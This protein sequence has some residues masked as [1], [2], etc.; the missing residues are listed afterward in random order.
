MTLP[1]FEIFPDARSRVPHI[2]LCKLPTGVQGLADLARDLEIGSLHVKRD[3]C[4]AAGYAGNK[5]RKLEFL[6][7][8]CIDRGAAEV[9]SFG[10]AGSNFA[11]ACAFHARRLG[12]GSI[13]ML[14]PQENA[15]YLRTNLLLSIASGADCHQHDHIPALLGSAVFQSL[16]RRVSGCRVCWIPAGGSSPAGVLG[17]VNAGLELRDQVRAGL[18]P[19]PDRIYLAMGSM[20][21]AAGLALGLQVAGLPTRVIGVRVV[22]ERYANPRKLE[23]LIRQTCSYARRHGMDLGDPGTA[24]DRISI[25]E[26]YLGAGYACPTKAGRAAAERLYGN[27][28]LQLDSTYSAKAMAA[29]ITDA[30]AGALAESSVLFWN[31]FNSLPLED[32]TAGVDWRAL[33]PPLQAYFK[34]AESVPGSS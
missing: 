19:E 2:S 22:E 26:G 23:R 27:G 33:P 28:G 16:R 4:S 13:S 31:T 29:L 5:I 15:E 1:L 3:D 32:R 8:D 34:A 14:L 18:L 12:L 7:A 25:R 21:S 24:L 9:L 11:T 10:F 30:K 6:L 20:G 17:F